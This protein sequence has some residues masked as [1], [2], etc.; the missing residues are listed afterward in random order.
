MRPDIL[1][2]DI[3][4]ALGTLR[5]NVPPAMTMDEINEALTSVGLDQKDIYM[6]PIAS[7]SVGQ[8]H[9]LKS[10][11]SNCVKIK[12]PS[13]DRRVK[14][15]MDWLLFVLDIMGR[16]TPTLHV[17][18][19][20]ELIESF[21]ASLLEELDLSVEAKNQ[22]RFRKQPGLIDRL[23]IPQVYASSPLALV[24]DYMMSRD[25]VYHFQQSHISANRRTAFA[26]TLMSSFIDMLLNGSIHTDAHAGNLGILVKDGDDPDD[27]DDAIVLYDYGSVLEIDGEFLCLLR[28]FVLTLVLEQYDACL[29]SLEDMGTEI[30]DRTVCII[31]LQQYRAY[32]STLDVRDMKNTS[33]QLKT[34]PCRFPPTLLKITKVFTQIEGLCLQVAPQF[35]Y[36][37]LLAKYADDFVTDPEWIIFKGL[38]D[39]RNF[40]SPL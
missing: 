10:D 16:Y 5:K 36:G 12:R 17:D 26:E 29:R 27:T 40:F 32:L 3:C 23:N 18:K 33:L 34:M 2:P 25:V 31:F 24:M 37:S 28:E 13:L 22:Q 6:T 20:K 39:A 21:Q 1:S 14:A 35:N 4:D 7:A 8:V 30:L 15:D 11:V 19:T 38:R 9:I